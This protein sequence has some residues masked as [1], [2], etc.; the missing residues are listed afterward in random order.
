M[1]NVKKSA[2]KENAVN[3]HL[4]WFPGLLVYYTMG[5][6]FPNNIHINPAVG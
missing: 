2:A 1:C 4:K 3:M 6:S 5:G